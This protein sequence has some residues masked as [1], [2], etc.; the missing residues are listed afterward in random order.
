MQPYLKS[1]VLCKDELKTLTSFRSNCTRGIKSNFRKMFSTTECPL[2]CDNE[3]SHI[4]NPSHVL[5]CKKN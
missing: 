2:Q 3:A 1:D 4:D 5:Q